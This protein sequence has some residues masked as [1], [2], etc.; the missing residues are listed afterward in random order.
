MTSENAQH[1]PRRRIVGRVLV[2][3]FVLF[4]VIQLVPYGRSHTNPKAPIS[5]KWTD[6]KT[7][8]LAVA[9]CADCHSNTTKWPWTSNVAPASWLIQKDIDE[10]RSKFNW[11]TGCAELGELSEIIRSG[12]M[13][14]IQYTLIHPNS[15]LSTSEQKHLA[16][17]L[18]K[19]LRAT[20]ANWK[21]C[22]GD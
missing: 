8:S 12:E 18:A 21:E 2:G 19:S 1:K 9:S 11:S 6:A 20:Q 5:P 3:L 13:P 7:K 17:G 10:G 4:I 16:D 22:G 14:P 15:R